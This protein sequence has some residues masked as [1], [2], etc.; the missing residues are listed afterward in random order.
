MKTELKQRMNK[1]S[2]RSLDGNVV[3]DMAEWNAIVNLMSNMLSQEAEPFA[4]YF[5]SS[6]NED[7]GVHSIRKIDFGVRGGAWKPLYKHPPILA[8]LPQPSASSQDVEEFIAENQR[9]VEWLKTYADKY[10]LKQVIHVS[11][12]R[13]WMAGHARVRIPDAKPLPGLMMPSYHE[14]IGWNACRTAMLAASQQEGV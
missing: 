7:E 5:E 6:G 1:V 12:L 10:S 2:A 11:D 8:P 4:S 14:A 9:S 13:A 3:M